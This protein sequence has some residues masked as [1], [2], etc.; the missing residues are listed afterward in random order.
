M[1]ITL[2]WRWFFNPA[3]LHPYEEESEEEP[4]DHEEEGAGPFKRYT[5]RFFLSHLLVVM[6]VWNV[7]VFVQ[8]TWIQISPVQLT[9]LLRANKLPKSKTQSSQ[10]LQQIIIC[11]N[12][13]K[14]NTSNIQLAKLLKLSQRLEKMLCRWFL[15]TYLT[16]CVMVW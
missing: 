13:F 16:Y 5:L 14:Y 6:L 2:M 3:I 10:E 11:P 7:E 12:L 8:M 9:D 4:G 15:L 1:C